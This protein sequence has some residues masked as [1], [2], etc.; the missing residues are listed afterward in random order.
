MRTLQSGTVGLRRCRDNRVTVTELKVRDLSGNWPYWPQRIV[1][2]DSPCGTA[3]T[4]LQGWLPGANAFTD[5]K[6]AQ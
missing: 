2:V 5:A 1:A 6:P 3:P 4:C